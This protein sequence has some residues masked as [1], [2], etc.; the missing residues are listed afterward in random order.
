M[1][2]VGFLQ[3]QVGEMLKKVP[4]SVKDTGYLPFVRGNPYDDYELVLRED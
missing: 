4:V 3:K 2:N 1:W